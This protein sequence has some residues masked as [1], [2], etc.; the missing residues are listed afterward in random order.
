MTMVDVNTLIGAR[1][2]EDAA[3]SAAVALAQVQAGR[4]KLPF[5]ALITRD[6]GGA[7]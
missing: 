1:L 4:G 6:G 7:R 3:L 5:A 2:D